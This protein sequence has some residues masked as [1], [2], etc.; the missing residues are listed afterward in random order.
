MFA[1]AH[2]IRHSLLH[3]I[4]SEHIH[5]SITQ[6]HTEAGSHV[7]LVHNYIY[8]TQ[9]FKKE[10]SVALVFRE[11]FICEN[12]LQRDD[13][14]QFI[15]SILYFVRGGD[16]HLNVFLIFGFFSFLFGCREMPSPMWKWAQNQMHMWNIV[17]QIY[18]AIHRATN[19]KKMSNEL[20]KQKK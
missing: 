12:R 7:G 18:M 4:C 3:R 20:G 9:R 5:T 15:V 17:S 1:G 10:Y 14:E 8:L 2:N 13:T 6:T 19:E 11:K 16:D